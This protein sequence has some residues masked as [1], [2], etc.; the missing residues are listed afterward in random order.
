MLDWGHA[1]VENG[2]INVNRNAALVIALGQDSRAT[3]ESWQKAGEQEMA[4][5]G[6]K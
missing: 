1:M 2:V 3:G 5:L 4:N 6:L